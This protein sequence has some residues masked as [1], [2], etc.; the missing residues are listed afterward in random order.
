MK[1]KNKENQKQKLN[2]LAQKKRSGQSS[3]KAITVVFLIWQYDDWC[4]VAY[5][6]LPHRAKYNRVLS[7]QTTTCT[8]HHV[9]HNTLS[10]WYA[11]IPSQAKPHSQSPVQSQAAGAVAAGRRW[12]GVAG[13]SGDSVTR[14][15]AAVVSDD[16]LGRPKHWPGEPWLDDV[17]SYWQTGWIGVVT[18]ACLLWV[19]SFHPYF[20]EIYPR[21]ASDATVLAIIVCMCVCLAVCVSHACVVSKR[22]NVGPRKQRHVIAQGL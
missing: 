9:T 17:P 15:R 5:T 19:G 6:V 13:D 11:P 12:S 10:H 21:D 1:R 16:S 20:Y 18:T 4:A 22:L 2:R 3:V 14:V 7:V 8:I